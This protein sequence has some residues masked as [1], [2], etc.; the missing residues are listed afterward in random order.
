MNRRQFCIGMA[1][2]PGFAAEARPHRAPRERPSRRSGDNVE[3]PAILIEGLIAIPI[4]AGCARPL[5]L[6]IGTAA[7][8]LHL[9][10]SVAHGM[11]IAAA[12]GKDREQ[13]VIDRLRAGG[14]SLAARGATLHNDGWPLPPPLSG[15][16]GLDVFGD[17][18]V[19]LNF[20]ARRV[21][22]GPAELPAPDGR[23]TFSYA[24]FPRVMVPV[25]I[26]TATFPA[27]VDTGQIRAPLLLAG[28]VAEQVADAEERVR[29]GEASIGGTV[30]P[31]TSIA[32]RSP[33]FAGA[34][35]LRVP[36]AIFPAP[37]PQSNLGALALD[38]LV[39]AIDQRSRRVRLRRP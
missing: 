4:A 36:N 13:V 39:L 15:I 1:A 3:I 24:G 35:R 8:G 34:T 26:G 18:S 22:I 38:G 23:T 2:F 27:I 25:T 21:R 7:L 33:V 28:E 37:Y 31:L 11:G 6:E 17:L 19:E 16:V 29:A 10:R 9:R 14:M 20:S 32:I 12:S 30:V 5:L